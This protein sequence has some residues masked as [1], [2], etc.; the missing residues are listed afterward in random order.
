M[1]RNRVDEIA[2]VVGALINFLSEEASLKFENVTIIGFSLGAHIAGMTG[3]KFVK[4][5]IRKVIGLDPAGPRFDIN[6]PDKRLAVDSATYTECIHTGYILGT[7]D[8]FCQA[9]FYVNGGT[10]QPGC[11]P[12]FGDAYLCSHV[13]VL[14][15]YIESLTAPKAFYGLRCES[16][17][18][19]LKK[20]C[21]N[22]PGAFLNNKE[23]ERK[24]IEG[25]FHVTT[26]GESPYGL[27]DH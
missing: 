14:Y 18:N 9:D 4:S 5:P 27:G 3:K 2:Q 19:A 16:A 22:E 23:N 10:N 24:K 26:N 7:R 12:S 20:S 13:R 17:D 15:I 6:D 8:P 11:M 25:I 21:S 1:A